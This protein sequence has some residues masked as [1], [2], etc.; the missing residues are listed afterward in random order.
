MEGSGSLGR[1]VCSARG[2]ESMHGEGG[3]GVMRPGRVGSGQDEDGVWSGAESAV[4]L[5]ESR[6]NVR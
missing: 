5:K 4:G 6:G 1:F 2:R 3:K